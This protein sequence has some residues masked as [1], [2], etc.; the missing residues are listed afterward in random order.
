[1]I[2]SIKADIKYCFPSETSICK[3][4]KLAMIIHIFKTCLNTVIESI[5][6]CLKRGILKCFSTA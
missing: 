3:A 2:F 1:M 5:S 4:D 6:F